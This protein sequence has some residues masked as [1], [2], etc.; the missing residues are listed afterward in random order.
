MGREREKCEERFGNGV[1]DEEVLRGRKRRAME[2]M[3]RTERR[4][5]EW[6]EEGKKRKGFGEK[7]Q[8]FFFF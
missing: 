8:G 1:E 7:G 5:K 3:G 6:G 4:E 2:R